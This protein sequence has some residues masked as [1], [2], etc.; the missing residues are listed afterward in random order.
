MAI[1]IFTVEMTLETRQLNLRL[2]GVT[3]CYAFHVETTSISET[4]LKIF[5]NVTE[6]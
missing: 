2:A 1:L 6:A 4:F 5:K 3:S